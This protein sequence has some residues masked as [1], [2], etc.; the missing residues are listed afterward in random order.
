MAQKL[1]FSLRSGISLAILAGLVYASLNYQTLLD[2]WRLRGYNPPPEIVRL[3]NETTMQSGTRRLFYIYRPQLEGKSDFRQDCTNNEQTI[4]LGCYVSGNGIFLLRVDDSRLSGVEE[5]TAAH[6]VLHAA[7]E[8]LSDSE[9]Q[10]VDNMTSAML[11]RITDKRIL[12]TVEQYRASDPSSVPNELHSILG[13]EVSQLSPEL[14]QYYSKYFKD[15]QKIIKYSEQY[16]AAFESRENQAKDILAQLESLQ[17]EI[18]QQ[19]AELDIL[20]AELNAQYQSLE[21]ARDS[22]DPETFNQEASAYNAKVKD[23]NSKLAYRNR[24]AEE[25][26]RLRDEYNSLVFEEKQLIKAIDS[27]AQSF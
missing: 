9:R 26:N 15:R 10:N 13:T 27:R 6:E 5:V 21:S 16:Q 17:R 2:E 18:V 14:E 23:F 25:Y 22:S 1:K 11:S 19:D 4:V 3:A 8:R 12:D 24:L 20:R 7:Y